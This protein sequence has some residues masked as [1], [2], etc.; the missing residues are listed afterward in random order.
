MEYKKSHSILIQSDMVVDELYGDKLKQ[1]ELAG[2]NDSNVMP[3]KS[4]TL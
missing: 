2:V 4:A 3:R 1:E